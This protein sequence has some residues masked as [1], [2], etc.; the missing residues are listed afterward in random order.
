MLDDRSADAPD[1]PNYRLWTPRSN[2]FGWTAYLAGADRDIAVPARR[3]DLSGLP[4]A[5]IGVGTNDLFYDEDV[6]YA[7]RLTRAGV[8]CQVEVVQGAFHGFDLLVPKNRC[9]KHSS[10]AS[11][12][13]CEQRSAR[14]SPGPVDEL[15][16]DDGGG[17]R[18]GR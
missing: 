14:G 13:A 18:V 15:T 12:P 10:P 6:A 1:N 5:W 8:P 4:P 7:E 9:R 11:V 2:Q 3:D 16:A 17:H